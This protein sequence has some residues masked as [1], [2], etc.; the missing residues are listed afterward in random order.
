MW[1]VDQH[2]DMSEMSYLTRLFLQLWSQ[3]SKQ[4]GTCSRNTLTNNNDDR[5]TDIWFYFMWHEASIWTVHGEV[6]SVFLM[7]NSNTDQYWQFYIFILIFGW[8][9]VHTYAYASV[10]DVLKL[11]YIKKGVLFGVFSGAVMVGEPVACN[12]YGFKS[13][14]VKNGTLTWILHLWSRVAGSNTSSHS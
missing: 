6:I 7:A 3:R 9:Y 11:L 12:F 1:H 5:S 10:D 4:V 13:K 2:H 14:E 8:L